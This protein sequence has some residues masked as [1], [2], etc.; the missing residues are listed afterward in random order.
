MESL[1]LGIIKVI[2]VVIFVKVALSF[3]VPLAGRNAHPMLLQINLLVDRITEPIFAPIRRYTTFNR[4][5]FSPL[6]VI[7]V[8]IAIQRALQN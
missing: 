2:F 6:V 7:L 1:I 4:F 3:I 5:D 8:L